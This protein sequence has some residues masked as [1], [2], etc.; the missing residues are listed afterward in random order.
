M[1][2]VRDSKFSLVYKEVNGISA[3]WF[4]YSNRDW[5]VDP[6]VLFNGML[7]SK[8]GSDTAMLYIN[9]E[10][11]SHR[12]ASYYVKQEFDGNYFFWTINHLLYDPETKMRFGYK[13]FLQKTDESIIRLYN[14]I[15]NNKPNAYDGIIKSEDI[16]KIHDQIKVS[17][18]FFQPN[19]L[20]SSEINEEKLSFDCPAEENGKY[21]WDYDIPYRLRIGNR[22][23]FSYISDWSN[24]ID[25]VRFQLES[26]CYCREAQIKLHFEDEPTIINLQQVSPLAS[27]KSTGAHI[28][29]SYDKFVKVNIQ[30]NSFVK[31]SAVMG[32]CNEKETIKELY[33]GLLNIGRVGYP[34]ESDSNDNAW[35]YNAIVFYNHI[36][37]PIIERYVDGLTEKDNSIVERQKII[38]YVFTISPDYTHVL[39]TMTG[40]P[41]VVCIFSDDIV[42][43]YKPDSDEELCSVTLPGVYDWLDEFNCKSDGVN[44][45]M[46]QMN[47]ADWHRRGLIL[48]KELKK[49]L[50]E[51]IDVWYG[52]PFEDVE[53]RNSRPVLITAGT[54]KD[55]FE[56]EL[57]KACLMKDKDK[58]DYCLYMDADLNANNGSAFKHLIASEESIEALSEENLT[59]INKQKLELF[60]H[61]HDKGLIINQG[62]IDPI[63][64]LCKKWKC[65]LIEERINE[66]MNSR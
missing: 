59:N 10:N 37:S 57:S 1:E 15:A 41:E 16:K 17:K 9:I 30:P 48:A 55:Y 26:Y 62:G 58:I 4:E 18:L 22:E 65:N 42:T 52:Y 61:L 5:I 46:G 60:E 66:I 7:G 50:P 40:Q 13:E 39:G 36:K 21:E 38:H 49:K 8:E 51:D 53:H 29:Y 32:F 23:I 14:D 19:N 45:T 33:E 3:I 20:R 2:E 12:R 28:F 11:L 24:N 47:T 31:G 34:F 44:S 35:R 64:E 63:L 43:L 54:L 25:L 27:A 6:C 56:E